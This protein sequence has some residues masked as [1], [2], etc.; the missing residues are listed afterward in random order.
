MIVYDVDTQKDFMNPDGALSV[1]GAETI[2]GAISKVMETANKNDILVVGSVDA[3]PI[4]DKEFEVYPPHCV[5]DTEGQE[6]I[7]ETLIH[8]DSFVYTVPNTGNGLDM[9]VADGCG[10]IYFEKQTY[11]I[12]D[13]TLGQPDNLQT[14][15][16]SADVKDI[17]V[18]GVASNVC[19]IAAVEGFVERKYKVHVIS[20]AIKG[21]TI[22]EDN[23]EETV[24]TKMKELG[25]D[26][27]TSD[28]F[29]TFCK[30]E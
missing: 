20:D 27:I 2:V 13:K 25:V 17:Y 6:K 14:I 10:Q 22:S 4:D 5:V 23:N 12:W 24:I 9:Y 15:L 30:G 21:L 18:M 3:H 26:F 29:E 19:V 16:R 28:E 1:P 8:N 7:P 11:N